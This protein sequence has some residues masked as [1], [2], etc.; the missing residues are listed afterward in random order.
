MPSSPSFDLSNTLRLVEQMR[1]GQRSG[2]T[3]T[4]TS[5]PGAPEHASSDWPSS[6][7]A[8]DP[9]IF[10]A[11][12]SSAA[13]QAYRDILERE[14]RLESVPAAPTR[15]QSV[16]P[17]SSGEED[18]TGRKRRT[19]ISSS[20]KKALMLLASVSCHT[21]L[22]P[23]GKDKFWKDLV[24]LRVA[25]GGPETNWNTCKAFF[26]NEIKER[27]REIE[28]DDTSG[29]EIRHGEYFSQ[30]DELRERLSIIEKAGKAKKQPTEQAA[31]KELTRENLQRSYG[32]K[33]RAE[34]VVSLTGS[35]ERGTGDNRG[36]THDEV[37]VT[38]TGSGPSSS[39]ATTASRSHKKSRRHDLSR[40]ID[41]LAE[42]TESGASELAAAVRQATTQ[43]GIS[44]ETTSSNTRIRE[45]VAELR[46]ETAQRLDALEKRAEE[47]EA[48]RNERDGQILEMLGQ[49]MQR[50]P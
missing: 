10:D 26:L 21:H 29:R 37:V 12:S 33:R 41:K 36:E 39:R 27:D 38:T 14:S 44:G 2:P 32:N 48:A 6:P 45:M 7:I 1:H 24:A 16:G 25:E 28:E 43:Q 47:R 3:E 30:L 17:V 49:L 11:S 35:S 46:E 34:S 15:A 8:I 20:E 19:R 40:S 50:L 13:N 18:A 5:V 31:A 23:R 42:A 9:N 22:K 4:P